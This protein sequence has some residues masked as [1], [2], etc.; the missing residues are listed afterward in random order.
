[1]AAGGPSSPQWREVG[2]GVP[3]IV[4]G[5]GSPDAL[6]ALAAA[7][8][9]GHPLQ[10]AGGAQEEH[11]AR[12]LHEHLEVLAVAEPLDTP[13]PRKG[14][15]DQDFQDFFKPTRLIPDKDQADNDEADKNLGV[16]HGQWERALP[17]FNAPYLIN[18]RLPPAVALVCAAPRAGNRLQ[19]CSCVLS[20]VQGATPAAWRASAEPPVILALFI[21]GETS[22]Q[23]NLD[24]IVRSSHRNG[25]HNSLFETVKKVMPPYPDRPNMYMLYVRPAV[26][27]L[28]KS[29]K[30]LLNCPGIL[31]GVKFGQVSAMAMGMSRGVIAP[32]HTDMEISGLTETITWDTSAL[33]DVGNNKVLQKDQS[34]LVF[35]TAGSVRAMWTRK[36]AGRLSDHTPTGL[37]FFG[38]AAE[39]PDVPMQLSLAEFGDDKYRVHVEALFGGPPECGWGWW[40]KLG[41]EEEGGE[42]KGGG[43]R[44]TRGGRRREEQGRWEEEE[45][46]GG[47]EAGAHAGTSGGAAGLAGQPYTAPPPTGRGITSCKRTR[48][49]P[50]AT[51]KAEE[52]GRIGG[53]G[54]G[55]GAHAGTSDGSVGAEGQPAG[56]P[57]GRPA[58]HGTTSRKRGRPSPAAAAAA[59]EEGRGGGGGESG[60]GD[61][62]SNGRQSG[63]VIDLCSSSGDEAGAAGAGAGGGAPREASAAAPAAP[64]A[65]TRGQRMAARVGGRV[66]TGAVAGEQRRPQTQARQPELEQ[67]RR[68]GVGGHGRHGG[69]VQHQAHDE[70]LGQEA[71]QAVAGAAAVA[72]QLF[73]D[74]DRRAHQEQQQQQEAHEQEVQPG[75][76]WLTLLLGYGSEDDV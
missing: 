54:G 58:G 13:R 48:P 57:A 74:S 35:A 43:G 62:D 55:E 51:A 72:A 18:E 40:D 64:R 14:H 68:P 53:G 23:P 22:T 37:V 45:G 69:P 17:K 49:P 7:R 59:E 9:K 66:G 33:V 21:N 29:V 1:M 16:P 67:Q 30:R 41:K 32:L 2:S 6:W 19:A 11:I 70:Q 12:N 5:K 52:A 61:G 31:P 38:E 60:D 47:E 42:E 39:G 56:Q 34:D 75:A 26:S 27:A 28:R 15:P 3:L 4:L 36:A 10:G 44:R 65:R 76:E 8:W 46:Q 24:E 63:G 50:T 20:H 71:Q 73:A 25:G